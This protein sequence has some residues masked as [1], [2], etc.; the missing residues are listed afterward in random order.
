MTRRTVLLPALLAAVLTA[1]LAALLTVSEKAEASF[2]GPNGQIAFQKHDGVHDQEIYADSPDGTGLRQLT[3]SP[4]EDH[5]AGWSAS[6]T[7]I[8]VSRFITEDTELF[9]KNLKAG[10]QTR[11][12]SN[13]VPDNDP[14]FSPDNTKAAFSSYRPEGGAS[15]IYVINAEGGGRKRLTA[16]PAYEGNPSWSPDGT[17]IA[18]VRDRDVWVMDASDGSGQ[19]NLTPGPGAIDGYPSWSPDGS[20][21]AFARYGVGG[22]DVFTVD[23]D[24]SGETNV[25][26]TSEVTESQPAWSPNG[27]RIAFVVN[28]GEGFNDVWTMRTDGTDRRNVTTTPAVSEYYPDW[29]PRPATTP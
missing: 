13:A 7:K 1:C 16:D 21:I 5:T 14:A 23:A 17:R 26:A 12:T 2:P 10:R 24:G 20:E 22:S 28:D 4:R 29:G 8:V 19:T 25:T 27:N 6:G 9:V 11:L 15:D 3:Y 18:F